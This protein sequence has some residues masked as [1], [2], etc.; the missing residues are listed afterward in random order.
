MALNL[1]D[2]IGTLEK[3]R[4]YRQVWRCDFGGKAYYLKFYPRRAAKWKPI[5]RVSSSTAVVIA[6]SG[7]A[8]LNLTSAA[9][10][11]DSRTTSPFVSRPSSPPLPKVS[12][13]AVTVSQPSAANSPTAGCSMSW[14][15]V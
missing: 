1:F 9:R 11:R 3:D 2:R 15:S 5:V 10:R 8:G 12:S 6:S 13:S 4:G 14:S 7:S